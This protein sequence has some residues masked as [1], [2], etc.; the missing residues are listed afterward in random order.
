MLTGVSR[1]NPD[2]HVMTLS[3]LVPGRLTRRLALQ[4]RSPRC[5]EVE[6]FGGWL[7]TQLVREDSIMAQETKAI[8]EIPMATKVAR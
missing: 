4:T 6:E 1:L 8:A 7:L 3:G 5:E 2:N